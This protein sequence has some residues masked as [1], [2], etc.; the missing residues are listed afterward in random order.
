MVSDLQAIKAI[1]AKPVWLWRNLSASW[2][3]LRLLTSSADQ[4]TPL[5]NS[6][7]STARSSNGPRPR[8][9]SQKRNVADAGIVLSCPFWGGSICSRFVRGNEASHEV[10]P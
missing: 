9:R 6:T 4:G 2:P 8:S 5:P 1:P 7:W 10:V 3:S